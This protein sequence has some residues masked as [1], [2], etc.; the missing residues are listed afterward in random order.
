M[1]CGMDDDSL[2][3]E[4]QWFRANPVVIVVWGAA[5]LIWWGFFRQIIEGVPFG[6]NPAPDW[7]MW[8]ILAAFGICMPAL[9]L[10]L[11]LE[12][13]VGDGR[14]SY[15]VYPVHLQFR[16]VSCREIT[17]AESVIYRPVREY[18]GWGFRRGRGDYAY[19]V[20]GNRGVRISLVDGSSKL[21][22][23]QRANELAAA[24]HSCMG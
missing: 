17:M 20:S 4:V 14:L 9:F 3:S 13:R 5:L 11:R 7:L 23:S 2:F 16:E 10:A 6:S 1:V 12:V 18:G 24:L 22:G 15:R 19:T 21:I 8:V